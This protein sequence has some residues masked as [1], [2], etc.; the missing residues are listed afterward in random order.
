MFENE[1]YPKKRMDEVATLKSGT[2]FDKEYELQN[3]D[4]LYCKVSDMNLEGNEKY[5]LSS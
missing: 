3:G 2:T 4:L 5:M 1:K